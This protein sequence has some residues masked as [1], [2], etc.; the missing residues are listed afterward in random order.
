M[1]VI[2]TDDA[3]YTGPVVRYLG[4][5]DY[6][7]DFGCVQVDLDLA[8]LLSLAAQCARKLDASDFGLRAQEAE[9]AKEQLLRA[10]ETLQGI[11]RDPMPPN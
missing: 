8:E 4:P 1:R 10:L 3:P 9:Q 7:L 2:C 11:R 6:G 5:R